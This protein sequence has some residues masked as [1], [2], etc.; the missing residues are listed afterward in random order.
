MLRIFTEERL[1]GKILEEWF[2]NRYGDYLICLLKKSGI[3]NNFC[4]HDENLE[5]KNIQ[6]TR[7]ISLGQACTSTILNN[8]KMKMKD[9]AGKEFLFNNIKVYP[10]YTVSYILLRGKKLEEQTIN[11]FRNIK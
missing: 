10:W 3:E 4:I 9:I 1:G 5:F 2:P 11:F 7:I 6:T 8:K